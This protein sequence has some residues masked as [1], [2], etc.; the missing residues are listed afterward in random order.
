MIAVLGNIALLQYFPVN[1]VQSL[2]GYIEAQWRVMCFCRI[3]KTDRVSPS[4]DELGEICNTN[5]NK[6]DMHSEY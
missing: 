4:V 5:T 6:Y 1:C 2:H 3:F